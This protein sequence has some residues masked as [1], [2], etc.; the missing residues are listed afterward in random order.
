MSGTHNSRKHNSENQNCL[1]KHTTGRYYEL[2]AIL[3]EESR[4]VFKKM[5]TYLNI[6]CNM[7]MKNLERQGDLRKSSTPNRERQE[8]SCKSSI[9]NKGMKAPS[10]PRR[11][12]W[13]TLS[14]GKYM[15]IGRS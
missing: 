9:P 4:Y 1:Y 13:V 6:F 7:L 14:S 5:K 3:S 15:S 8:D 2:S 10:H 11:S 12:F